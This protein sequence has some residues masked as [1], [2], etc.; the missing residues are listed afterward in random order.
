MTAAEILTSKIQNAELCN[1][2]VDLSIFCAQ[3]MRLTS[4]GSLSFFAFLH[5]CSLVNYGKVT[6]VKQTAVCF[7]YLITVATISF[8]LTQ[9]I[10]DGLFFTTAYDS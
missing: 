10:T 2:T 9:N 7:R 4:I 6:M 3:S 5:C 8:I 1:V